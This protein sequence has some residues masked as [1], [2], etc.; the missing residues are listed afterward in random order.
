[1]YNS[2]RVSFLKIG[3]YG[4]MTFL[5]LFNIFNPWVI[6]IPFVIGVLI[7]FVILEKFNL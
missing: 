7:L 2:L 3:Y 1:M 6:I 5:T 4:K